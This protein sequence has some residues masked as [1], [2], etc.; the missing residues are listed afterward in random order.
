LLSIGLAVVDRCCGG[1]FPIMIGKR[2]YFVGNDGE[3]T[4]VVARAFFTVPGYA[5][6]MRGLRRSAIGLRTSVA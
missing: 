1:S 6:A 3:A 2:P 5:A 4:A